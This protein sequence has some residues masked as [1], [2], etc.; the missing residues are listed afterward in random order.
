ML[1]AAPTPPTFT[2]IQAEARFHQVGNHISSI[3]VIN[4]G[5]SGD[6]NHQV[7]GGFSS[8]V[9]DTPLGTI[10]G[11]EPGFVPE[12]S[13]GVDF[14]IHLQDDVPTASSVTAIR[15]AAGDVFFPVEMNKAIPTL[16]RPNIY[17]C[18]IYKHDIQPF[19]KNSGNDGSRHQPADIS[20]PESIPE[21]RD[22][23]KTLIPVRGF[24]TKTCRV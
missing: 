12:G 2:D 13:Q 20:N 19:L 17:N 16:A 24:R 11:N 18:L 7:I 6:P 23:E 14:G 21:N 3:V 9:A 22:Q 10:P 1:V 15:S 5:A 8:L 4:Q